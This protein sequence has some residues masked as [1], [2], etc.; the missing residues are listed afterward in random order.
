MKTYKVDL[1]YEAFLFDPEYREDNPSNQKIIREFEYVFFLINKEK[2]ILKN[3]KIYEQSYLESL[4]KLDF[5]VP[6]LN[7]NAE[8]SEYWWGRHANIELERTLNSKLTSAQIAFENHWGFQ[9]GAIVETFA[10]LLTHL[11]KFP[12]KEKWI[13]KRPY[14]FSGIGHNQ[15][16][17]DSLD[18]S[19]LKKNLV[20]K[21]L[22]EPVYERVFDIGTTFEVVDGIIKR[23]FMVE[24]FNTQTGNFSGG[25]GASNVDKFKKYIFQKY[26]YSLEELQQ[27]TLKIAQTY[28]KLGAV[29]NIQI[30][31]FVYCDEGMLKTYALVEVNYRKTMG[32]VIQ[33]LAEKYPEADWVEWRVKSAKNFKTNP[34]DPDWIKISPE[35]NH[36]QSFFKAIYFS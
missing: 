4:K 29:S 16:R 27:T 19:H 20:G 34:L 22:L 11:K 3:S 35:G 24:N 26:A 15:F 21:V 5:V 12:K 17:T 13:I 32:L 23:Q 9:E 28:L 8:K 7:P 33:S 36:F 30:D 25:A 18:E 31:S 2:A 6:K 10:E 14:S 1:D